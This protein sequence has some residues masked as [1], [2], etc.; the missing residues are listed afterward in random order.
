MGL[1]LTGSGWQR[2]VRTGLSLWTL[3]LWPEV[4]VIVSSGIACLETNG[5][6]DSLQNAPY[7][8]KLN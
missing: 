6:A 5:L 2:L 3:Q 8:K 1:R 4:W 7:K